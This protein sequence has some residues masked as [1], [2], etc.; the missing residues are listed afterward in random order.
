VQGLVIPAVQEAF[1]PDGLLEFV[2]P[3]N[4]GEAL[5]SNRIGSGGVNHRLDVGPGRIITQGRTAC[6]DK[7]AFSGTRTLAVRFGRDCCRVPP[8]E[9][10]DTVEIA[11]ERHPSLQSG[12]DFWRIEVKILL[13]LLNH[14]S[15]G[16]RCGDIV[17]DRQN[18]T[19]E[20]GHRQQ[21]Q[22]ID[23]SIKMLEGGQD[24]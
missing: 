14:Q 16:T 12:V 22:T 6:H 5:W 8:Q 2:D 7:F 18:L 21:A 4:H 11:E 20:V 13:G 3:A 19:E 1:L 10:V 24:Q 23:F 9:M 17:K 15:P